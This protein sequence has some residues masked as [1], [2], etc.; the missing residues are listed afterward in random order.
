MTMEHPTEVATVGIDDREL[1]GFDQ[2]W[3]LADPAVV[4]DSTPEALQMMGRLL[5]KIGTI[6]A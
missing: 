2:L 6:E 3:Q 5:S 4:D 1:L